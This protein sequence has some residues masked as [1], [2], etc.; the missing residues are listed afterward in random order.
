MRITLALGS[1]QVGGTERQVCR[2]ATELRCRGHEVQVI[3]LGSTGPLE[4]WLVE[5]DIE[6]VMIGFRG[7]L[8]RDPRGRPRPWRAL[9]EMTK[10]VRI[11]RALR[12]HRPD[13]CHAFLYWAYVLVLPV[14]ALARVPVRVSGRRG[15][16]RQPPRGQ[17]PF[18]LLER[19]VDQVTHLA[20][21]N[22]EAVADETEREDRVPRSKIRV[23]PNGIDIPAA[24]ADVERAPPVGVMVANLIAYKG[25]ADLL[26]ALGSMADP[27]RMRLLGDGPERPALERLTTELDLAGTVV[28][29]GFRLRPE[30][31]VTAS[32]FA[33]LTSHEEGFPN[34]VLEAMAAGLPVVATAVGGVPELVDRSTGILVP[35]R[36]PEALAAAIEKVAADPDLRRT[37]GAA[38]R[39]HVEAFSWPRCVD[40]HVAL[41]RSAGARG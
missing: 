30:E 41:Y 32:Q 39:T 23:I 4:Q 40:A 3:C 29:E 20:V 13:V 16:G 27:P 26:R 36:S 15:L 18:D 35:P 33:V 10:L 31:V 7:F 12:A 9:P 37:L 22:A 5:N 1:L 14:A 34:A 24:P 8:V 11:W 2:L 28:F 21:C 38:A 6:P 19:W 25:H 17:R